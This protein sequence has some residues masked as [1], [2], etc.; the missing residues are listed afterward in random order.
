MRYLNSKTIGRVYYKFQIGFSPLS[1]ILTF[2]GFLT[3]AKVWQSTFEFYNV[4]FIVA[5]VGFPLA[6]LITAF[7]LGEI[8][9]RKNVKAEMTSLV[10]TEGNP[11]FK[12]LCERLRRIE[13]LMVKK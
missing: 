5:M 8:M 2:V 10:N 3:F 12:E 13:E 4:P 11:E 1:Y 9:I 7:I 6:M